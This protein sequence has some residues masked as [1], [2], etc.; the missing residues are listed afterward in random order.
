MNHLKI[1]IVGCTHAG[2][3]A[4]KQCL[5]YTPDAEI[6]VYER[7]ADISYLSC[8]TYLH[9]GGTVKNLD[10][11][12]YADPADFT[13]QGVHMRLQT[14][15]IK[16][17]AQ[18]HTLLV[19]DL[20]TKQFS[21]DH[22]DKLIMATGSA[23]KIP[24][25]TGIENPKVMLC[26]TCDQAHHLYAAAQ[27]HHRI[28]I[29]GGGYTGVELAEG[30]VRSGHDVTLF[31][32]NDQLLNTYMDP[33][34]AQK[35]QRLLQAK[36]VHVV[37]G[38]D[39]TRFDETA[40]GLTVTTT[41]AT[42]EV[43][44]VAVCPGILPQ[45]DLLKG[46]VRL[47]KNGAIITNAYMETSDP[48]ILA[49]GDVTEVRYNPTLHTTYIPLASHA[50][51]QGALAGMNVTQHRLKSIG[52]QATTGMLLFNQTVACTGLT[53]AAAQAAGYDARTAFYQGNYRPDFMPTTAPVTIELVYDRTSRRIL[54][55]QLMSAHEVAQ[56]ANT[57]SVLIQNNNTIDQMAFVD[58]LFSPN[59]DE[60]FNYLNLVAQL[61][62]DQEDGFAS[63]QA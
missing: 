23:T 10:A 27:T 43:D 17:D 22:Y 54:G 36:G 42:Y 25:I 26:K 32:R 44:M 28:G 31:Q 14:D 5:K 4:I 50:I 16:I 8:G 18:Q 7:H 39:V 51:R 55:A 11:V 52:T 9:L 48:D 56:S 21:H 15:V 60:P 38:A 29:L 20:Q 41:Q 62:V 53:L 46:Q 47:S 30:Y 57:V 40:T 63:Q 6:T 45:S 49:A 19:Q 58:M 2:I 37:T 61:A 3:A 34:M 12:F 59:F 13:Q 1:I 35:V 33:V 24:V